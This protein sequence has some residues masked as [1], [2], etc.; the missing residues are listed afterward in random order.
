MNHTVQQGETLYA[1]SKKYNI[2]TNKILELNG[3]K[4]YD[5]IH[6]GQSLIVSEGAGSTVPQSAPTSSSGQTHI[7]QRGESLYSI[8]QKYGATPQQILTLNGMQAN[9][10]I[11]V[12]QKLNVPAGG[13]TP[14]SP[15]PQPSSGGGL[16]PTFYTVQ[17]G[18]SLYSIS[19]KFGTT[20]QEII[21]LN[22]MPASGAINVGQRLQVGTSTQSS[23]SRPTPTTPSPQPGA[24]SSQDD[25][26][27]VQRGDSLYSIAQRNGTTP[28]EILKMNNLAP[29]ATIYLGQ[30]LRVRPVKTQPPK[31]N[32][33]L[34]TYTV[35]QGDWLDKI[36]DQYGTTAQEIMRLN[37]LPN[38]NLYIGQRLLIPSA[39]PIPP[40]S[41]QQVTVNAPSHLSGKA[42]QYQKAREIFQLQ[43]ISGK[44]I[45]GP[46][47]TA[48]VGKV[49]SNNPEDLEK[50]QNRLIQLGILSPNH[51]ESP[52]R[53]GGRTIGEGSIP[54]TI[55][56]ISKFQ[57]KYKVDYWTKKDKHV[58]MMGT[59][60]F[61]PGTVAPGDITLKVLREY[62]D[63]T[64][65]V[66]HP[67]NRGQL[68]TSKFNNFVRSS[69]NE[70]YDGVGFKG[71]YMPDVP[72]QTF[73]KFGLDQSMAEGLK[74]VSAHEGNFDAIN[75][76][77][78]ANFSW[79]FI[80][81]AGKGGGTNGSLGAVIATMKQRQPQLFAEFFQKVGIDID[82]VMRNGEVHDGNLKIFDIRKTTGKN[83][84]EGLDAEVALKA[85][86]Q[87]YG[88]FIRA[89]YH[90][91]M[92]EAQIERSVI[93]YVRPA[94]SIKT[95]INT[96][97]L[98]LKDVV[99]NSIIRSPMGC[100]TMVDLTV[101]QWINKTRDVF[102]SA[103][104]KVARSRNLHSPNELQNIDE[105]MVLQQIVN[106]AGS[107]K[108]ISSRVSSL[109]NS[110][111]SAQKPSFVPP[112]A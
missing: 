29:N 95:D 27:I 105:R 44:D 6:P 9:Q 86:K 19:K 22:N 13:S 104:E 62:E 31:T 32:N 69:Y 84:V 70:Y 80:Q 75:S 16:K 54:K 42:G 45:I 49:F 88:A 35:K 1:I 92:Y 23:G 51:G 71:N 85:D 12:G 77:D 81:F 30:M 15:S 37:K 68:I 33:N 108:R 66:P 46:G 74:Y 112:I 7:V 72:F 101:N 97:R 18:D 57:S 89:A 24:Q 102:K 52:A 3:L 99:L 96:G 40:Q 73:A 106:D 100:A 93:G 109:L 25:V 60:R 38:N 4:P 20:P 5:S 26:Y 34:Q 63:Y 36:A 90:P 28:Q 65:V 39:K 91:S 83:E 50:V 103:I 2:S 21:K 61:T 78:K 110:S 14:T 10:P 58:K 107:D 111:L 17:R 11:Y 48:P 87:L 98:Q 53:F 94:L 47:L 82:I 76:Y 64:L 41:Q 79:G 56:A 59:N 8:A 55:Q 43:V 67:I